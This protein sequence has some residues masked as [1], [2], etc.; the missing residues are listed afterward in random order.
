MFLVDNSFPRWEN[1]EEERSVRWILIVSLVFLFASAWLGPFFFGSYYA[2]RDIFETFLYYIS[3]FVIL[4][5][6]ATV[7]TATL[8]T[9]GFGQKD[10]MF[11]VSVYLY[12]ISMALFCLS[13][14]RSLFTY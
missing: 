3:R 2:R 4:L 12:I 1:L 7:A 10:M 11:R 9:T 6:V 8:S 5:F 13:I 14:L